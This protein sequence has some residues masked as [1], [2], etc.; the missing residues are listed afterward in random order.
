M[1]RRPIDIEMP[2]MNATSPGFPKRFLINGVSIFGGEA[3]SRVATAAMALV[4]A[5]FFGSEAL[6]NYGYALALTSILLI[7]PDFGLH[8][9]T[10]REVSASPRRLSEIFWGV[11]WAKLGL[12][13]LVIVFAS[14]FGQW[15]ILNDERRLL[16]SILVVRILLQTFSQA[17]MSVF[18]AL[19]RMQY[20][21]IQQFANS[22]VVVVWVGISL[23]VGAPLLLVVAG[24]VAGQLVETCLGWLILRRFVP[25]FRMFDK[26]TLISTLSACF[27][28]GLTAILLALNLRLDI[29]ILSL[30]RTSH[31]LGAYN[32]ALWFVIASFLGTSLLLTVL[33][34]KLSRLLA[35]R[36]ERGAGYVLSLVKNGLLIT[37]L[38]ALFVWLFSR[39]LIAFAFG[40]GFDSAASTL[41]ILAP[42]LP[43]GFLNTVF[44]YVFA[45]ARRRF[46]CLGTLVIGIACGTVLSMVLT[47]RYGVAGCATAAV[48]REFFISGIYIVFLVRG[49]QT[50][51][52]GFALAKI[53]VGATAILV[54][55]AL[56]ASPDNNETL[57]LATWLALLFTGTMGVL[58]LPSTGEWRLL[59]DDQP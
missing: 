30:Y 4:V 36:S 20:V 34:P 52:I 14:F 38:G 15:G 12:A 16:F 48:V 32:A 10:V 23:L 1:L 24:L 25:R 59:A 18:K 6:G 45:A 17:A 56:F 50:R 9:F 53:F 31:E 54:V 43:L 39:E 5:R 27:P 22:F 35:N 55:A 57:W 44:F 3:I 51:S 19:E 28:I 8:L 40:D 7:V 47:S 21:A 46:V 2:D 11:H 29:F 49:S 37:S 13:S 42:A 26:A 33:F 58:G 41:R